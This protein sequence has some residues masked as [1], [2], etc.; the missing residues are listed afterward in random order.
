MSKPN[1]P[2]AMQLMKGVDKKDPSR[3]NKNEPD[4]GE[5]G[6]PPDHLTD[7]QSEIWA[8]VVGNLAY[9]V[10][11]KSDRIALELMVKLIFKSRHDEA[12]FKGVDM[13]KLI[14][15]VSRFGMT[16]SDRRSIV[17]P[18]KPKENRFKSI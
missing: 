6:S 18:N 7:L 5:L 13:D 14:K 2:T 10:C 3:V 8:E 12:N 11:Q 4:S 1:Q 16:P 15:L 17:V 9:G